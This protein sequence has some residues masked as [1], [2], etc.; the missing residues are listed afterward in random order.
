VADGQANLKLEFDFVKPASKSKGRTTKK[1]PSDE[2]TSKA[3]PKKRK[4]EQAPPTAEFDDMYDSDDDFR[5][6]Q[7]FADEEDGTEGENFDWSFSLREEPVSHATKKRR[8]KVPKPD[9]EVIVL[10]DSD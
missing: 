5:P 8:F 6:T 7:D 4:V 9:N 1:R 3:P 2:G 10:S